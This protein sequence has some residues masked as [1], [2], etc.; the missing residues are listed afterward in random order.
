MRKYQKRKKYP[1]LED[2][3]ERK[4]MTDRDILEKYIDLDK[5]CLTAQKRQK[6][7]I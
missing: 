7:E 5:S 3:D 2:S 4:Y 1:W 6:L